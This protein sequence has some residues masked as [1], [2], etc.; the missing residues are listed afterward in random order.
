MVNYLLRRSGFCM[1]RLVLI[2]PPARHG[3]SMLPI[4]KYGG[5]YCGV[6]RYRLERIRDIYLEGPPVDILLNDRR[7]DGNHRFYAE[8]G[9]SAEGTEGSLCTRR[10][11]DLKKESKSS[12]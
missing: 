1:D 10:T 8:A 7:E 11:D 5:R 2:R 6:F 4:G 12:S 9:D 3:L